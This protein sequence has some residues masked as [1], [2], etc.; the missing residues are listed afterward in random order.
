MLLANCF[1][2]CITNKIFKSNLSTN[3]KNKIK[4]FLID[5][6]IKTFLKAWFS[7]SKTILTRQSNIR[8]F[9]NLK[10]WISIS[11]HFEIVFLFFLS[12]FLFKGSLHFPFCL[13]Y[14]LIVVPSIQSIDLIRAAERFSSKLLSIPGN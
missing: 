9:F 1:Q 13:S 2:T 14:F 8:R 11:C 12:L 5:G 6:H 10:L 7:K 4:T 3:E